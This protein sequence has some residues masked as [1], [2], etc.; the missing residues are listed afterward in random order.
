MNTT[1]ADAARNLDV[2]SCIHVE[3][4]LLAWAVANGF[5]GDR[6]VMFPK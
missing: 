5:V 1:M 6:P 2:P 4:D 3:D